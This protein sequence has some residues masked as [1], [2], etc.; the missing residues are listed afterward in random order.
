MEVVVFL[1]AALFLAGLALAALRMLRRMSWLIP[2]Y[3]DSNVA[4]GPYTGSAILARLAR[5]RALLGATRQAPAE[6]RTL[7]EPKVA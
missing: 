4:E 7:G 6:S 2:P 3:D 5:P 1:A